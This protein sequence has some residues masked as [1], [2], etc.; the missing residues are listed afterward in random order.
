MVNAL[1][2]NQV[3]QTHKQVK[4][5]GDSFDDVATQ[6]SQYSA[7]AAQPDTYTPQM[8]DAPET[9]GI[10]KWI[11]MAV[12][13]TVAV[14]G[15]ARGHNTYGNFFKKYFWN[16]Y[17]FGKSYRNASNFL[18]FNKDG[19]VSL[20]HRSKGAEKQSTL[21]NVFDSEI[22][23]GKLKLSLS[24]EGKALKLSEADQTKAFH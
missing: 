23:D 17:K 19:K 22:K 6:P 13:G 15:A 12:V 9:H 16:G 21:K 4:F 2:N 20:Y 5:S 11:A 8:A 3:V 10:K 18:K 14:V 24:E 1:S 7:P